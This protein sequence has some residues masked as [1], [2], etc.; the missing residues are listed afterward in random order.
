M[1]FGGLLLSG[2]VRPTAPTGVGTGGGTVT[3]PTA[4]TL[5]T[6]Q[7]TTAA[8]Q[9]HL[10]QKA[11]ILA[12]TL[13]ATFNINNLPTNVKTR[14]LHYLDPGYLLTAN[15]LVPFP[16]AT[17]GACP[18]LSHLDPPMGTGVT[19]Q[20]D[21]NRVIARNGQFFPLADQGNSGLKVFFSSVPACVGTSSESVRTWYIL[22]T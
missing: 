16:T 7:A 11:A 3:T 22:F 12:A 15:D 17:G 18:S 10:A 20:P 2:P 19:R 14:H 13:P 21:S 4:T 6:A 9:A 8:A 5:T 1:D